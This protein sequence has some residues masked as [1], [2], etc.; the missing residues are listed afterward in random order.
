MKILVD[1]DACPV[2]GII[3]KIAKKFDLDVTIVTDT[4]HQL[5][6]EEEHV[7]IITVEKG[8]DSVDF[9]VINR[10][11]PGDL[12]ITGD[13]GVAAM[14]LTKKALCLNH[15]G[16]LYEDD[17]MDFMLYNRHVS[18]EIR[19]AGGKTPHIKKRKDADNKK[20]EEGLI[21]VLTNL[22]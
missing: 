5:Y 22:A 13:Y 21:N 14:A 9:A 6:Y 2:N 12:V 10:V 15:Y 8:M 16:R 4:A 17:K 3:I 1:G 20:F 18:K 7:Q 11:K 19:K